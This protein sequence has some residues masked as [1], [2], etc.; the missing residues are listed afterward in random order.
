MG[1]APLVQFSLNEFPKT[2]AGLDLSYAFE[3]QVMVLIGLLGYIYGSRRLPQT[4]ESAQQAASWNLDS[5]V[6]VVASTL[7]LISAASSFVYINSVGFST[8]FLYRSEK[9]ILLNSITEDSVSQTVIFTLGWVLS[10]VAG[11]TFFYVAKSNASKVYWIVGFA[12]LIP[13]LLLTN[14]ISTARFVSI[15]VY[16]GI[17]LA[18]AHANGKLPIR[19]FKITFVTS[20]FI[21]FPILNY[22]RNNPE[23]QYFTEIKLDF[24]SGDYDA[25]AQII[26]T[27]EYVHRTGAFLSDQFLGPVLFWLPRQIWPDKPVDTGILL[28]DFKGYSFTNLS[29]PLWTE[30][31]VSFSPIGLILVFLLL[32]RTFARLDNVF[33]KNR[34]IIYASF[35]PGALYSLII[36]RGSLLQATGGLVMLLVSGYVVQLASKRAG[37]LAKLP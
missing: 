10:L 2:T 13:C 26:N 28:A 1:F 18:L 37:R 24:V 14:P 25:F 36:L 5:R 19:A 15:T 9:R 7:A 27:V 21:L 34:Q 8:L 17:A 12:T 4:T 22:F 29:A 35:F 6:K 32:G 11:I 16:G 30:A 33:E 20:I 3:A 31:L 23:S